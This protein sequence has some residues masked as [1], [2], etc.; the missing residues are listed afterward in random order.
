MQ[1]KLNRGRICSFYTQN[2]FN[3]LVKF[4]LK[5]H[6]NLSNYLMVLYKWSVL[7]L[8]SNEFKNKLGPC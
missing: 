8:V 5:V 2:G 6:I 1:K 4:G 7:D 3:L